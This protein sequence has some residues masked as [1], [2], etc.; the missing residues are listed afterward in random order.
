MTSASNHRSM[1]SAKCLLMAMALSTMPSCSAERRASNCDSLLSE[2][3]KGN[4]GLIA[5]GPSADLSR[6][7]AA[8]RD[9]CKRSFERDFQLA[10]YSTNTGDPD[11]AISLLQGIASNDPQTEPKRLSALYWSLYRTFSRREERGIVA[12]DARARF[13]DS[14]YTRLIGGAEDCIKGK[15][16]SALADLQF[17]DSQLHEVEGLQFLAFAYAANDD[18]RNAEKT[19]D[20]LRRVAGDRTMTER[21]V[22]VSVVTYVNMGRGAEAKGIYTRFLQQFPASIQGNFMRK[23]RDVLTQ[24]GHLPDRG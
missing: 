11:Q 20:L 23:S 1:L 4:T 8:L 18:F 7:V 2:V 9:E 15:C 12:A 3:A 17:A 5:G 13:P 14:P 22:Y 6:K 24:S 10:V 16:A 19:L 21:L